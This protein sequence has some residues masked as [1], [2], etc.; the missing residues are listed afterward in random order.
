VGRGG[1]RIA[2]AA[3]YHRAALRTGRWRTV[4]I[5]PAVA[6]GYSM[7]RGITDALHG[8]LIDLH[9]VMSG[10]QMI[11]DLRTAAGRGGLKAC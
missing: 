6:D 11:P 1:Y 9:L 7:V 2:A 4:P 3:S 10:F 8:E 5:P